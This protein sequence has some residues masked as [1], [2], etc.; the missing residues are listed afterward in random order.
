[1]TRLERVIKQVSDLRD[2][3][4][5]L[6]ALKKAEKPPEDPPTGPDRPARKA[7]S[8]RSSALLSACGKRT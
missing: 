8:R 5:R 6:E 2:F 1:M 4:L 7:R 3:Y